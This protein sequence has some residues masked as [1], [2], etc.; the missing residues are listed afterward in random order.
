MRHVSIAS[1]ALLDLSITPIYKAT[2]PVY[3]LVSAQ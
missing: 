2:L 3:N 1:M